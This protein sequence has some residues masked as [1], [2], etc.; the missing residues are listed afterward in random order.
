MSDSTTASYV[1][2][3]GAVTGNGTQYN[4]YYFYFK[5]FKE[6]TFGGHHYD[7]NPY[8]IEAKTARPIYNG[9]VVGYKASATAE[10]PPP[11]TTTDLPR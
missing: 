6:G 2:N 10:L 5:Y 11:T 9:N 4:Y 1:Y 8:E 3:T 7:Y